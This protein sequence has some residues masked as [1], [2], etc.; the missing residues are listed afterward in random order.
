MFPH[1]N[2]TGGYTAPYRPESRSSCFSPMPT[3]DH[4]QDEDDENASIITQVH[5]S[6]D[7]MVFT[8]SLNNGIPKSEN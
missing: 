4:Q 8:R 3:R 6:P 1:L 5:I 7:W 2:E